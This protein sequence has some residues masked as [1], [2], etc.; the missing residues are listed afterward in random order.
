MTPGPG[1]G[2][3]AGSR[4]GRATGLAWA[5]LLLIVVPA[6]Q[7]VGGDGDEDD[8][9]PAVA[10]AARLGSVALTAGCDSDDQGRV[11]SLELVG[12]Y[13]CQDGFAVAMINTGDASTGP[14]RADLRLQ[15]VAP[16]DPVAGPT[17][18]GEGDEQAAGFILSS[19]SVDRGTC[20]VREGAAL[21]E[22]DPLSGGDTLIITL[23]IEPRP[24][25]A[26]VTTGVDL[27][28]L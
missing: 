25:V 20:E 8:Q 24:E 22:L 17:T 14:V 21:C 7:L 2:G 16:D 13:D 9:I 5:A 11:R 15:Q 27:S 26:T 3:P 10:P 6:C 1:A 19:A 28:R 12:S 23:T 4:P 18:P